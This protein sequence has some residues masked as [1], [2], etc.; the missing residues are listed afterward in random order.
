MARSTD[1]SNAELGEKLRRLRKA[2]QLRLQEL[3]Q[4]TGL[5]TSFLSMVETGKSDITL[6]KLQRIVQHYGITIGSLLDGSPDDR[7]MTRSTERRPLNTSTEGVTTELMVPD[8]NRQ[9]EALM[10]T[11]EPGAAYEGSLLHE[12]EEVI[13]V[14]QGRLELIL[15]DREHY[16]LSEGDTASYSST[17]THT[18]RNIHPGVSILYGVVT[19]P[20]L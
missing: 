20:T 10:M 5:S 14:V 11:F 3:A 13:F 16:L 9:L 2:R 15:D 19:P 7:V 4:A 18:F 1:T 17:R 8:L 12:G 6:A